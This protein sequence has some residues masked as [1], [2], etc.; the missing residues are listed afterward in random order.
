V[1]GMRILQVVYEGTDTLSDR[2]Y[3]CVSRAVESESELEGIFG[4][5]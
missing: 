2:L 3:V 1:K 5:V 4:G